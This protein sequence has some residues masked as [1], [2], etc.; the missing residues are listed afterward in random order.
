M[1]AVVAGL[2]PIVRTAVETTTDYQGRT[3]WFGFL[4]IRLVTL[5]FSELPWSKLDP[6]FE[7]QV[8]VSSFCRKDCFNQHF[9]IPIVTVWN[10][11]CIIFLASVL[12]MELFASHLRKYL[13]EHLNISNS[14]AKNDE[15]AFISNQESES[16]TKKEESSVQKRINFHREKILLYLYLMCIILRI[17]F[18]IIFLMILIFLHLPKVSEIP[19]ICSTNLCPG[20]FPCVVRALQDK[21]MAVYALI[22]VSV[23]ITAVSFFFMA[24]SCYNYGVRKRSEPFS[25]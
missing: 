9:N 23:L 8:N 17:I 4:I 14:K 18:E 6:D 3:L 10:F 5:Y 16:S 15:V 13:R 20:P 1:A 2:V 11:A 25:P 24:Y 12:V 7:C 22:V 21:Q 19:I